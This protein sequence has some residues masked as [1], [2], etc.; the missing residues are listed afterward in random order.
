MNPGFATPVHRLVKRA[1]IHVAL[2]ATIFAVA[3]IVSTAANTRADDSTDLNASGP[4]NIVQVQNHNDGTL[5]VMGH[6]QL[7][8]VPGPNVG[9]ANFAAAINVCSSAC[10]T[11]AVALQIN[12]VNSNYTV[13][14]PQNVAVAVNGGCDGCHA[15]A[16]AYQYNIGVADPTDV[17][18]SVN[19]LIVQMKQELAR[20]DASGSTL[21]NAIA[22]VNIVIAQYQDLAN[23]LVTSIDDQA[24]PAR[25]A[26][27]APD[28]EPAPAVAPSSEPATSA[29]SATSAAEPSPSPTPEPSPSPATEP[30]ASPS[31]EATPDPSPS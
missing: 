2:I 5:R 29:T 3:S 27:A 23:D 6:V 11:L 1:R 20:L 4:H 25:P 15:I 9:P 13:F 26:A 14:A 24:T 17:P 16:V 28:T 8:R 22:E 19:S 18:P 30:V 10:D 21:E 31:A 7:G 12:L